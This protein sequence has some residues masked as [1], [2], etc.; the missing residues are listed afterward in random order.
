MAPER[1]N[2]MCLTDAGQSV[3]DSLER[4]LLLT[5]KINDMK[6]TQDIASPKSLNIAPAYL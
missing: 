5:T 4:A 1:S 3:F 6:K 2:V